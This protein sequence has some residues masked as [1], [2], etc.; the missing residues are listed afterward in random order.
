MKK[1]ILCALL[2][3]VGISV[4]AAPKRKMINISAEPN[5]AAIY[6]N[7]TFIANGSGEFVRP[8]SGKMAVIIHNQVLPGT[9]RDL[10]DVFWDLKME[11][12]V[13]ILQPVIQKV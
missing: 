1:S 10:G 12:L 7:N 2:L 6:V 4:Q 9:L 11:D 3:L 8:K 13:G 5:E